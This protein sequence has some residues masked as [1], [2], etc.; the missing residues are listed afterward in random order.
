MAIRNQSGCWCT[1]PHRHCS[2]P[3]GI[4]LQMT[5]Q[6]IYWYDELGS[7]HNDLVGKKCANLGEMTRLGLRVPP[8]FAISV[9][10]YERFMEESGAGNEIR[11]Y[12]RDNRHLLK[13]VAKQVEASRAIR[14]LI[15]SKDMPAAME[16]ELHEHYR[17]LC[18]LVGIDDLPVAVRSSGAIS[19]PGQMETYLNVK[20]A[21]EFARKVIRVWGSAFT[22]RAIAFRV[23]KKMEM[24]RAPIGVA[25]LKMVNAKCAGVCL[26][27]MPTTGDTSKIIIEGNWGLGES[28][29]SG[30]ITPDQFIVDKKCGDYECTVA[31]KHKM[32]CYSPTG[33]SMGDV[34]ADLR[35]KACL[36][37]PELAEIVRVSKGVEEHFKVPQDME[38]VIDNDLQYPEN[39]FWVQARPAKYAKQR[40]NDAEYLAE[41]MTRVFKM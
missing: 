4:G 11:R 17:R 24:E 33:T 32:I 16:Q 20:G 28:V 41:L 9:D 7:E 39:I 14:G 15:E 3:E 25:V 38:W 5:H 29:V 26:T 2:L 12:V 21:R 35:C 22:T 10:G 31:D 18:S 36:D 27:V 1:N 8:G 23:E 37:E 6:W 30:E 34:P 13:G 40:R 19:M